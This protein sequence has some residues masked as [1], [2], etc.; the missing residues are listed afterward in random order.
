MAGEVS[1]Q[2]IEEVERTNSGPLK[3]SVTCCIKGCDNRF[4]ATLLSLTSLD[5]IKGGSAKIKCPYHQMNPQ[6]RPCR[7]LPCTER[8]GLAGG[9]SRRRPARIHFGIE[10]EPTGFTYNSWIL[11]FLECTT[12]KSPL[13]IALG[14]APC[15][16]RGPGEAARAVWCFDLPSADSRCDGRPDRG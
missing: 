9:K 13:G 6:I 11:R 10:A 4:S 1:S 3:V 8:L 16:A 15:V 5:Y 14:R 7:Q 2:F 12:L